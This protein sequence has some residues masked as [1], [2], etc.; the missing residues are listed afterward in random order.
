MVVKD[1][2]AGTAR[3][4]ITHGPEIIGRG[5]PDDPVIRETGN[6]FPESRRFVILGIDR[7]EQALWIEAE[8]L[9]DQIPAIL[10]RLFLEIV[11]KGEVAEHLEEGVVARSIA[12]IVEVIVLAAGPDAFL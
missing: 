11:A 8:F 9:G 12:D 6:L 7:D 2:R 5:D 4:G 1:F 3:A 10:D